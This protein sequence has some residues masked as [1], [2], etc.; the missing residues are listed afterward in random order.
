MARI[1]FLPSGAEAEIGSL[2][3]DPDLA[4]DAG[5]ILQRALLAGVALDHTCGGMASCATCH[6]WIR[7][8]ADSLPA[9][10]ADELAMLERAVGR[11]PESRLACQAVPDGSADVVVEV[12]PE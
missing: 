2:D 3:A 5:A 1:R 6:C 9:P 7:A 11:R 10:A 4:C 12:P 8:G